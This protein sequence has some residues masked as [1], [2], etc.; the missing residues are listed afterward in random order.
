MATRPHLKFATRPDVA[1][2]EEKVY[3]LQSKIFCCIF[4]ELKLRITLED[5]VW[6]HG[7]K[8]ILSFLTTLINGPEQDSYDRKYYK[9]R[10]IFKKEQCFNVWMV[11][12][13]LSHF[14]YFYGRFKSIV[15]AQNIN[16]FSEQDKIISTKNMYSFFLKVASF[17]VPKSS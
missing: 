17:G 12:N 13:I 14:I 8:V 6:G 7:W 1:Q 4:W 16:I 15:V 9:E 3:V 11:L 2:G 10:I 5:W